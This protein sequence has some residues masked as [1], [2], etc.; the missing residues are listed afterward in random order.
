[1]AGLPTA[2]AAERIA[3]A[4]RIAAATS[5]GGLVA[6]ELLEGGRS[7]LWAQLL[8]QHT[9]LDALRAA[10]PAPAAGLERVRQVLDA[11]DSIGAPAPPPSSPLAGGSLTGTPSPDLASSSAWVEHHDP[12]DHRM[13]S[14]LTRTSSNATAAATRTRSP[15]RTAR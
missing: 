13:A 15:S 12:A 9:E 4:D 3:A 6:V 7:V 5:W 14:S 1:M 11:P 2:A 10:A 8:D